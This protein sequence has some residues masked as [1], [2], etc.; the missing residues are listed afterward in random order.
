MKEILKITGLIFALVAII[1]STTKF[2]SLSLIPAILAV[3]IGGVY[4]YSTKKAGADTK[5][6]Q[7]ISLLIFMT[8]IMSVYQH[9]VG[10][11]KPI[12]PQELPNFDFP[13]LDS[14]KTK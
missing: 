1:M 2:Y 13:E 6:V 7:Y 8:I 4:F 3:I 9:F 10:T 12:P 14:T 5:P 11:Q